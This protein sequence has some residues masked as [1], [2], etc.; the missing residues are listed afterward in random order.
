[1]IIRWT[2]NVR[3]GGNT[4]NDTSRLGVHVLRRHGSTTTYSWAQFLPV[5][6]LIAFGMLGLDFTTTGYHPNNFLLSV[7]DYIVTESVNGTGSGSVVTYAYNTTSRLFYKI[8]TIYGKQAGST[9][10]YKDEDYFGRGLSMAYDPISNLTNL[11][12]AAPKHGT[13]LFTFALNNTGS[14]RTNG[15]ITIPVGSSFWSQQSNIMNDLQDPISFFGGTVSTTSDGRYLFVADAVSSTGFGTVHIYRRYINGEKS[16]GF[17]NVPIP[18]NIVNSD[19]TN[20]GG[21]PYF[22]YYRIGTFS[23]GTQY[24]GTFTTDQFGVVSGDNGKI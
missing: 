11:I 16:L 2:L 9:G 6:S 22:G 4:P 23:K 12:V 14:I 20:V 17:E 24:N 21:S 13:Q 7:R 10:T 3:S 5:N 15:A 8:Q 1:M 18:T 19:R